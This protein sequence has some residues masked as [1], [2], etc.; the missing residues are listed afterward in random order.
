[1]LYLKTDWKTV[2]ICIFQSN[3]CGMV[4]FL[5]SV[6][7][8]GNGVMFVFEKLKC[9]FGCGFMC[10]YF[11]SNFHNAHGTTDSGD[12]NNNRSW[13][14]SQTHRCCAC[15]C[16]FLQGNGRQPTINEPLL[17]KDLQSPKKHKTTQ[18][19]L[20]MTV[21]NL[22]NDYMYTKMNQI[23]LWFATRVLQTLSHSNVRLVLLPLKT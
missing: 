4:R 18:T 8:G 13:P 7:T 16:V 17:G 2:S 15:V 10:T 9:V 3:V 6:A 1:M 5:F 20:A 11:A 19:I 21:Y 23:V 12:M 22:N 14:S